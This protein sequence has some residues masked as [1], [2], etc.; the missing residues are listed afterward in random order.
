MSFSAQGIG[1]TFLQ[2]VVDRANARRILRN[3]LCKF[4]GWDHSYERSLKPAVAAVSAVRDIKC[5]A[6]KGLLWGLSRFS[7]RQ[8]DKTESALTT[9]KGYAPLQQTSGIV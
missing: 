4:S 7:A 6:R 8:A 5:M 1:Q 3:V 9:N 2:K